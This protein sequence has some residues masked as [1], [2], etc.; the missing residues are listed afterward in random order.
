[1]VTYLKA[2]Q[3]RLEA[4]EHDLPTKVE[5]II[6]NVRNK[7]DAALLEYSRLFDKLELDQSDVTLVITE[8]HSGGLNPSIRHFFEQATLQNRVMFL[9]GIKAHSPRPRRW[10][11]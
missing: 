2:A 5:E 7:G 3:P 4:D 9:T 6:H 11:G 1:M 8:P 10:L